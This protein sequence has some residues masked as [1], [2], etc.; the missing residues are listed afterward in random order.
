VNR[1]DKTFLAH[2]SDLYYGRMI[3]GTSCFSR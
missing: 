3:R 1:R 2:R